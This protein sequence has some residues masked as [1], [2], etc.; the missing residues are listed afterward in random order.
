VDLIWDIHFET[1]GV[2]VWW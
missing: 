1:I 2:L